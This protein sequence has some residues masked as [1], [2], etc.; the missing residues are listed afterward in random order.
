MMALDPAKQGN[1]WNKKQRCQMRQQAACI[2][3]AAEDSSANA[4]MISRRLAC[5]TGHRSPS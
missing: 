5:A 3:A 4:D 2:F 1:E